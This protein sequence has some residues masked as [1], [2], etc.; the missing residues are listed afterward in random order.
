MSR[1]RWA[2]TKTSTFV[3]AVVRS[4]ERPKLR[5]RIERG[6]G[7]PLVAA[8]WKICRP[9]VVAA[10]LIALSCWPAGAA[11]R[12]AG[13]AR[14]QF[15]HHRINEHRPGGGARAAAPARTTRQTNPGERSIG[16]VS[17]VLAPG[18]GMDGPRGSGTV[19]E[20]QRRL[21][22]A[23][24]SPGP[25]DGRY[26]PRTEAAVERYQG[27]RGLPVDGIVGPQTLS[28]LRAP[29]AVLYPGAGGEPGG[30]KLV[31]VLQRRLA[32]AGERPGAIDGRYGGLTERAVRRFQAAS[33]LPADGIAGPRTFARLRTLGTPGQESRP[34]PGR[35]RVRHRN[36]ARPGATPGTPPQAARPSTG[37][38]AAH[39]AGTSATGSLWPWLVGALALAVLGTGTLYLRRGRRGGQGGIPPSTAKSGQAIS[40]INPA[41]YASNL[42]IELERHGDIPGAEAAYRRADAM[43]DANGAF[44]LGG[45]LADRGDLGGAEAAYRRADERGDPGGAANLGDLLE[46]RGDIA[47]AT[48]AYRRAQERGH[49]GAAAKLEAVLTSHNRTADPEAAYSGPTSADTQSSGRWPRPH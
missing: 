17:R 5:V 8:S 10:G 43:G 11:A 29:A 44:N 30:S 20:L 23:G 35:P 36:P 28:A 16:R 39:P 40:K 45:L 18:A 2:V 24:F 34:R 42:G 37:R 46:R 4:A 38:P 15:S 47:G 7:Q 49:T 25:I 6:R 31:R 1:S 32:R 12:S 21:S 14:G 22:R 19:R 13:G 26:G 48:D 9:T 3:T 33:G 27:D 41:A